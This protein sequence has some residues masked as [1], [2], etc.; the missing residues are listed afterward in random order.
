MCSVI[1]TSFVC[2]SLSIK[3]VQF[4]AFVLSVV[5]IMDQCGEMSETL[6]RA[7]LAQSEIK[8]EQ[9]ALSYKT[10]NGHVCTIVV[11]STIY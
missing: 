10:T 5:F 3:D 7:S 2:V 11:I 4:E 9:I 6:E 8:Q 1:V